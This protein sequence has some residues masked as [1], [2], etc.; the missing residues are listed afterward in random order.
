M[1]KQSGLTVKP[2]DC[3][4]TKTVRAAFYAT[5]LEPSEDDVL[6]MVISIKEDMEHWGKEKV[7][8]SPMSGD[9][10]DNENG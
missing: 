1:D 2:D 9:C 10:G 8:W 7:E 5:D 6:G 4:I 3:P